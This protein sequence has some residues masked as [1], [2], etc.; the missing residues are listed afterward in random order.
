V[1]ELDDAAPGRT[2]DIQL[3][4]L[5]LLDRFDAV[6]RANGIRYWLAY[7]SLLGAARHGGFIPWDDDLDVAMLRD[8][9]LRFRAVADQL[10]PDFVLQD[11]YNLD[12]VFQAFPKLRCTAD[13]GYAEA[14]FAG[15]T[16]HR[17]LYIDIFIYHY[18]PARRSARQ[19]L[20]FAFMR[21]VAQVLNAR[22]FWGRLPGAWRK[23]AWAIAHL[24]P[25]RFLA[26]LLRRGGT[27]WTRDTST[28]AM[29][30]GSWYWDCL[31]LTWL[32]NQQTLPF[33][34]RQVPVPSHV[35]EIL[36]GQYGDWRQLPPADQRRPH[37][38]MSPI[39]RP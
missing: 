21:G 10:G 5:G 1:G 36:T 29:A 20:V 16:P 33:E 13:L 24:F 39:V 37:H 26:A 28:H 8:D 3:K 11:Y 34:G 15:L 30:W 14:A 2:R 19:W 6:C 7:G 9:Y 35:D 22:L 25:L 23:A 18:V 17:G 12:D 27:W 38:T 31:P 32:E 4:L